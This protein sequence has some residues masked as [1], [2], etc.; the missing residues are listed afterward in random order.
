VAD[1]AVFMTV[2]WT[3][4]L[5]GPSLKEHRALAAWYGRLSERP[6]FARVMAEIIAADRELSAPVESAYRDQGNFD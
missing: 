1:I 3:R 6:A 4:R 5:G 2:F